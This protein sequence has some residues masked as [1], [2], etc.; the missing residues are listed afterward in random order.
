[1]NAQQLTQRVLQAIDDQDFDGALALLADDFTFSGAV[2]VPISG[3]Q[4]IGVHRALAAAMPDFRFNYT[5][6][7]GD[8][9]TAEGTVALTGT[10]TGEFAVPIPGI[11]RVP[12]TGK[13]IAL[14]KER[15][16]VTARGD[17]LVNYQVESVPDGGLLGILRQMGVALPHG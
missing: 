4:W 10:H 2:P 12:A 13:P 17:K 11:P 16:R 7:G 1:M 5:P 9:G 3:E 15:V 6:T 8:N 14:P